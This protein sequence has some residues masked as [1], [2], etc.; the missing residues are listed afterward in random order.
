[1]AKRQFVGLIVPATSRTLESDFHRVTP[2]EVVVLHERMWVGPVKPSGEH[3][4]EMNEDLER[5]CR[6]IARAQV[7]LVVYG[8][9]S[10]SFLE[11]PGFDRR[12]IAEVQGRVGV[13]AIATAAAVVEALRAAGLRR[14]SVATPYDDDVNTLMS[15]YLK[16]SG[17]EVINIEGE[18]TLRKEPDLGAI[19]RQEPSVIAAFAQNVLQGR[20]DGLLLSCTAW[21][22]L[23][24]AGELEQHIGKPVITSNQATIW[25]ALKRLGATAQGSGLGSL[26]ETPAPVHSPDQ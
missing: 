6:Y 11:G 22:A 12:V 2:P 8:C 13:P 16:G 20:A 17:F 24:I 10:G 23:D 4:R 9:T 19:S 26:F 5:A 3:L 18:P 1:M 14:L 15:R 25:L 21:R 7:E